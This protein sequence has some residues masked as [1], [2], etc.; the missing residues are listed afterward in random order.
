[1]LLNLFA[2]DLLFKT[3]RDTGSLLRDIFMTDAGER[4]SV[5]RRMDL[6]TAGGEDISNLGIGRQL[7]DVASSSG[8][9]R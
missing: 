4:P 9:D 3:P 5:F 6:K 8:G 2:I 1:M 7:L